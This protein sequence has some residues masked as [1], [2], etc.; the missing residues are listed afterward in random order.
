MNCVFLSTVT[1]TG[2]P[3]ETQ[4]EHNRTLLVQTFAFTITSSSISQYTHGKRIERVVPLKLWRVVF[5]LGGVVAVQ[6]PGEAGVTCSLF[7]VFFVL[8]RAALT[9][10]E[11]EDFEV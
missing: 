10:E 11:Q 2:S 5:L 9:S 7:F 1:H 4:G 8:Q 3:G 6:P